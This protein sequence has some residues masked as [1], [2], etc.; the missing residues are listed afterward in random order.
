MKPEQTLVLKNVIEGK[1]V[2]AILLTGFGESLT[3]Q[4]S[5]RRLPRRIKVNNLYVVEKPI[6]LVV[7]PLKS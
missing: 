2:L 1:E 3:F 6:I 7:T 4:S 5:A